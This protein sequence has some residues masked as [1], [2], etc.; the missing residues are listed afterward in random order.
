MKRIMHISIDDVQID[1]NNV[2]NFSDKKTISWLNILNQK[3]GC[4]VSLY[5]QNWGGLVKINKPYFENINSDWLKLGI[6]TTS[7][8]RD[9]SDM[10][11]SGAK[12]Q[13]ELFC[14][15]VIRLGGSENIIDRFPRLHTFSGNKECIRGMKETKICPAVGFLSADDSRK[16][17]YIDE[18]LRFL[19]RKSCGLLYDEEMGLYFKPTDMR[20]DWFDKS[21]KS[22]Y[23]Y[24]KPIKRNPYQ[25]LAYRRYSSDYNEDE[26]LEVF[27]HEW[28]IYKNGHLTMRK[29][30]IEDVC[31]FAKD[32]GYQYD[33][34]MN[35]I[36]NN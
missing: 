2:I 20:L 12:Q 4:K 29:K 19:D 16:S 32:Y 24:K 26:L 8:G 21:F 11:F 23:L 34:P 1:K 14:D 5:I 31:R 7:D 25:E 35:L 3:Y 28:Q 9:F 13:W 6:H 33:F 15:T 30:W 17:Y 22:K 18:S 27:T 36:N 10:S